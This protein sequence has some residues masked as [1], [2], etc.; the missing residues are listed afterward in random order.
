MKSKIMTLIFLILFLINC[1]N[2]F[3]SE[4]INKPKNFSINQSWDG[5][6]LTWDDNNEYE[7][8]YYIF[9]NNQKITTLDPG[10]IEFLDFSFSP[11]DPLA[12]HVSCFKDGETSKDTDIQN[13]SIAL[14]FYDRFSNY[15]STYWYNAPDSTVLT[16][17]NGEMNV[18]GN[19]NDGYQHNAYFYKDINT[20]FT[21][22]VKL[23]KITGNSSEPFGVGI[24]SESTGARI[25]TFIS[26]DGI[27]SVDEYNNDWRHLMSPSAIDY[28][29]TDD[30]NEI[31]ICVDNNMLKV[32]LNNHEVC[33][34]NYLF[35]DAADC[36]Y[37][38]TQRDLS[39]NFDDV[40][41]FEN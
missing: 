6:A 3:K 5:I 19:D 22:G 10:A 30:F 1:D 16:H 7:D 37:L 34:L 28:L 35:S 29:N 33:L 18:N 13:I 36:F 11:F 9:R 31:R 15:I 41:L 21:F 39:V 25:F 12:Y 32:Y 17:I 23:K 26:E 24:R 27:I 4:D 20:P 14:K 38:Y 2:P 40:Y 8:G